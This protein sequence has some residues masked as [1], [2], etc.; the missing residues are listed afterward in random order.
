MISTTPVGDIHSPH[1]N[2]E[3]EEAKK[4]K[5]LKQL[6]EN[7]KEVFLDSKGKCHATAK[8]VKLLDTGLIYHVP[9]NT[10]PRRKEFV[11]GQLV[12]LFN[13]RLNFFQES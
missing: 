5:E 6:P 7:L 11:E 12:L 8:A 4:G 13:S 1:S 2:K 3:G 9:D 10:K